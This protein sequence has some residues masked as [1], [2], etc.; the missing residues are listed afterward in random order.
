MRI[1]DKE[2]ETY[3]PETVIQEKVKELAGQINS[4][5]E[6]RNPMVIAILNGSFIFAADL[7]R[8]LNPGAEI[9]FIKVASY[10]QLSSSGNVKNLIGLNEPMAGRD[11]IILEDIVDTGITM[12]RIIEMVRELG[13]RSV[14]IVTL[15]FKPEAL[16]VDMEIKYVGFEIPPKFV[17]GYGLD[18]DG[19]GRNY[20]E[21]LQLKN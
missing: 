15:L 6:G 16:K 4:D 1:K 7:F 20:K 12:Q 9:T 5:Y 2:F 19:Q 18:Y 3:L 11:V 10:D 14:E 17:I 21:I 13:P 8:N